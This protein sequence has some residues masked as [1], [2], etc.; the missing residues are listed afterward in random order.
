MIVDGRTVCT[1]RLSFLQ[2]SRVDTRLWL[3]ALAMTEVGCWK[4]K[5]DVG[6]CHGGWLM[7]LEVVSPP[8]DFAFGEYS[9][10][11]LRIVALNGGPPVVLT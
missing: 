10:D 1:W 11:E 7:K 2:G 9:N 8:S 6:S 3:I 5:L 4:K